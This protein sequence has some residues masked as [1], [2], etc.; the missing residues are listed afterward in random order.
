MPT[1]GR[2]RSLPMTLL[3]W[4]FVA[5][6]GAAMVSLGAMLAASLLGVWQAR[7][8]VE[9]PATLQAWSIERTEGVNLQQRAGRPRTWKLQAQYRYTFEGQV[10][11]GRRVGFV[12]LADN[13]S[14]DWRSAVISRLRAAEGGKPLTVFVDPKAPERSVVERSL[15]LPQA[16]FIAVFLLFPCGFVSLLLIG[17][18]LQ[19]VG[20][21]TST[22]LMALQ[23][24][25]WALLHGLVALPILWLAA[26]RSIGTGSALLLGALG[27][28]ALTGLV[29]L[30]R[31]VRGPGPGS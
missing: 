26:P 18:A 5:V 19:A 31:A 27:L 29:T 4:F 15:A 2:K 1:A 9:V 30:L 11:E 17:T 12:P 3:A 14:G 28:L 8:W 6:F 22:P 21:G 13:V 7:G 25:L 20:G 10:H 23:L 16:V 24:P